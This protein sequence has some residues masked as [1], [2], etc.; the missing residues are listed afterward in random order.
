MTTEGLGGASD[1][2]PLAYTVVSGAASVGTS[3]TMIVDV[4]RGVR[5]VLL[6][7]Q[8]AAAVV[9]GGKTVTASTGVSIPAS[10][11]LTVPVDS[12]HSCAI[13]GIGT[14]TATVTYLYAP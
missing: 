10:S 3:A 13:Y 1:D 14:T 5:A 12:G 6:E 2:A 4:P 11:A 8:G 7:N 9:V